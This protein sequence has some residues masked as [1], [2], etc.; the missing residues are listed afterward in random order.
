MENISFGGGVRTAMIVDESPLIRMALSTLLHQASYEVVAEVSNQADA[1]RSALD[2]RPDL[3]VLDATMPKVLSRIVA[4]CLKS[5]VLVLSSCSGEAFAESCKKVGASGY[6]CKKQPLSDLF[7]AI[8]TMS[9]GYNYF[10]QLETMHNIRSHQKLTELVL[11][12]RLSIREFDVLIR[13]AG[14]ASNLQ[15]SE[16]L[17]LSNKTVSTYKS[18]IIEKLG[19]RSVVHL[20]EMARRH[21]LV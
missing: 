3:I 9:S 1:L 6:L 17:G 4:E 7:A 20:S 14:G 8:K 5:K 15:V 10:P 11:L 2:H 21:G 18:R 12:Q 16:Q 19:V 13:L